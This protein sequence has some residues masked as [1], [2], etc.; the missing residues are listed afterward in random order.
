MKTKYTLYF[1]PDILSYLVF[2][3]QGTCSGSSDDIIENTDRD[4][5]PKF[6]ILV[7]GLSEWC[8]RFAQATDFAETTT[9]P[10]FDWRCWH[11]DG[12]IFAKEVFRQLPRSY[13]LIY[14]APYEDR[15]GILGT[16]D[17]SKDPVDEII[18]SLGPIPNWPDTKPSYKYNVFFSVGQAEQGWTMISFYVGK[19]KYDLA[20][21][22][23]QELQCLRTW[24]ERIVADNENIIRYSLG[25]RTREIFM[26]PQRIGQLSQMGQIRIENSSGDD[27]FSAYVHRREF[28]RGIYLSLMS[29]F[30]FGSCPAGEFQAVVFPEGVF[31]QAYNDLRS[32]IIEWYITDELYFRSTVPTNTG[33]RQVNKALVLFSGC[34]SEATDFPDFRAWSTQ[35]PDPDTHPQDYDIWWQE[36]WGIAKEI[37]KRLPADTDLF[38]QCFDP[39]LPEKHPVYDPCLPK[40]IVPNQ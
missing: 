1:T 13:N 28:V 3:E 18:H 30:A 40:I 23:R 11:R 12:L 7:P 17:F 8:E 10:E 38:Y 5:P 34:F 19:L 21:Y 39:A 20:L 15:S 37:R 27:L 14:K 35:Q 33:S 24:L 25:R 9:V 29:F 36:G 16:I 6:S 22:D 31:R 2:H 26:M 4:F 32:D